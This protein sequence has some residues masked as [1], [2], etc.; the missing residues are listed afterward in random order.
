[1]DR[2]SSWAV[3]AQAGLAG[4]VGY[5]AI[6]L[7]VIAGIIAVVLVIL[8]AAGIQVPSWLVMVLWIILAVVVGVLAVRLILSLL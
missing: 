5:W 7:I 6:V 1:M 8:R 2:L 3:L 4:T